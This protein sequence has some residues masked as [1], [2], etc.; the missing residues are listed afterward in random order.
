MCYSWSVIAVFAGGSLMFGFFAW[1]ILYR[2]YLALK[3]EAKEQLKKTLDDLEAE[4]KAKR[5]ELLNS[6][7]AEKE[8]RLLEIKAQKHEL[9]RREHRLKLSKAEVEMEWECIHDKELELSR[10]KEEEGRKRGDLEKMQQA[11]RKR[12]VQLTHVPESEALRLLKYD[13]TRDCED[14]LRKIRQEFLMKPLTGIE[15]EARR[16]LVDTMQR[17]MLT[18]CSDTSATVVKIPNEETKGRLIGKEGRNIKSFEAATGTTL[19]IDESPGSVMVSSFD[20]VRREIAHIALKVLIRDGRINPASI[21]EVV[22]KTKDEIDQKIIEEGEKA[23][24]VLGIIDVHPEIVGILGKLYYR[25][26]NNQN[27]LEHSIEVAH[28]CKLIACELKLDP[29]IAKR[30]GMFHDLGKAMSCEIE[31]SHAMAAA[32]LLQKYG[33]DARVVNAVAASHN[34][35]I[36]ESVYAEILKIAD[37][38]SASRP[39]ARA[40]AMEEYIKRIQNLEV[41]ALSYPGVVEAYAIQAGRELRVIVSPEA[42]Q[43]DEALLLAGRI[44][45]HIEEKMVYP[46]KIKVTVIR[47]QRFVETAQ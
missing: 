14:E 23:L 30:C 45:T 39:G 35:V 32:N 41:L 46:G 17:L 10:M 43:D 12:L 2:R 37:A 19:A 25:L 42:Y 27:T 3:K 18:P 16:V 11:Y 9:D 8:E 15:N 26:S 13:L 4:S 21:E 36:S 33:E 47:E 1:M 31:N 34:E 5:I 24:E 44:R 29:S 38:L 22:Q 40:D 6:I 7:Q 28:A 20:P